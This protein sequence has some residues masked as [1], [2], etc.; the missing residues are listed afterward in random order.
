MLTSGVSY[1]QISTGHDFQSFARKLL[2]I[3][4]V[5]YVI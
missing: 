4:I 1:D 3:M 5:I 2:M